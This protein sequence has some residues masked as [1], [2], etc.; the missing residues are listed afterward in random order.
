MPD[1]RCSFRDGF[2]KL[3]RILRKRE[4]RFMNKRILRIFCL[5]AAMLCLGACSGSGTGKAV[6]SRDMDEVL[7]PFEADGKWGYLNPR[8]ETV[9]E[10]VYAYAGYFSEGLAIFSDGERY[11]Y[12]NKQNQVVIP[13]GYDGADAFVNGYAVVCKGDWE[14]GNALWGFIDA[15]GRELVEPRFLYAESFTPEGRALVWAFRGEEV[16]RGFVNTDGEVFIPE[17]Y[18]I[19]SRF[20]D[21]LALIRQDNLFGY[22]GADYTIA[23]EPRYTD[24]GDFGEGLAYAEKDGEKF[25]ID[26]TGNPVAAVEHAF[27]TF[28]NGLA[29]F[30]KDDLY[31]YIDRN[32]K[33]AIE[34][35]FAWAKDFRN[36]LAAVQTRMEA[37]GKWGFINTSGNMVVDAVY[38]EVEDFTT[39]YARAYKYNDFTYYILDGNGKVVHSGRYRVQ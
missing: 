10:P 30:R 18:E 32:G 35:R 14:S 6:L 23:I 16:V 33:I 31:G 4:G 7:L 27:G 5:L 1:V 29:V 37:G 8:G 28:S 39:G 25:I 36:G 26:K 2:I 12:I 34:P 11:G 20:S 13:P 24:A 3:F 15:T 22:I 21:G 38:D 9:I 19:C 17:D